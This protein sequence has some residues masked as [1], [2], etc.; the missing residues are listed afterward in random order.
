MIVSGLTLRL[1]D[2][3][4]RAPTVGATSA[5]KTITQNHVPVARGLTTRHSGDRPGRG[6]L[7]TYYVVI[8][9]TLKMPQ[10][11]VKCQTHPIGSSHQ[12]MRGAPMR[13]EDYPCCGHTDGLGCN[14]VPDMDHL[15]AM[16]QRQWDDD[17]YYDEG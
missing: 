15:R 4:I 9:D 10:R 12:P 8:K 16:A 13:C 1:T 6:P 14:Y 17:Y 3:I 5:G 11:F 2:G 7:S